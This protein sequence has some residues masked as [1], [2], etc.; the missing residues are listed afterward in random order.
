MLT[1]S[2]DNK[3]DASDAHSER[4]CSLDKRSIQDSR[5]IR[6]LQDNSLSDYFM[7]S[8]W[9]V[10]RAT[11]PRADSRQTVARVIKFLGTYRNGIP[12][13]LTKETYTFRLRP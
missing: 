1:C 9:P 4:D 8:I 7:R 2:A 3:P 11:T 5:R 10:P 6:S 12:A 13:N